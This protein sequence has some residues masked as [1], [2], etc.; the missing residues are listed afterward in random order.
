MP[1]PRTSSSSSVVLPD[2]FGPTSATCSPR[3]T[4]NEARLSNSLL[5]ATDTSSPSASTTVR[6]LR[7][8]LRNSKPRPRVLRESSATSAAEA[9]RSCSSRSIWVNLACA[10]FALLFLYRNRSTNRSSRAMSPWARSTS[11]CACSIRAAFSRRHA[12]HGP[13]KNVPRPA[14]SSSVAVVTA[15][16]NQR[17]WATRITAASSEASSREHVVAQHQLLLERRSLIVQRDPRPL[18]KRKLAPVLLGLAGEDPQQRRLAGAVGPGE[19]DAVATLDGEGDAVE[20]HGAGELL[21]EVGGDDDCNGRSH[22]RFGEWRWPRRGT[23]AAA[24]SSRATATR[25]AP[26]AAS[27]ASRAAA[28]PTASASVS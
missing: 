2:P 10:C 26:A 17:S 28:L 25:S 20:E 13:G 9:L 22:C 3:S 24:T 6:P 21:A 19:R 11:F 1:S 4:A 14:S 5:L 8:G 23:F 27:T 12:C 18:G 15:S 16:R 7:A